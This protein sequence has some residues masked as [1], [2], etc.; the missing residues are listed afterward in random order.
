V[1]DFCHM[2]LH[3][4]VYV[5][6][7]GHDAVADTA[8]PVEEILA[9][10]VR[11]YEELNERARRDSARPAEAAQ[12]KEAA[13]AGRAAAA[14]NGDAAP[15]AAPAAGDG[16]AEPEEPLSVVLAEAE[17]VAAAACDDAP[18][19]EGSVAASADGSPVARLPQ[20]EVSDG[21]EP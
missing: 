16:S 6:G 3:C 5:V 19:A 2:M 7:A 9:E 21:E 1:A 15:E 14:A 17:R 12:I 20:E 11:E 18:A 10:K 4:P 8:G 13:Q